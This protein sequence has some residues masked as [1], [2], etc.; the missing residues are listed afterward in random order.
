MDTAIF[1]V[2]LRFVSTLASA[3]LAAATANPASPFTRVARDRPLQHGEHVRHTSSQDSYGT[4]S[5]VCKAS[6]KASN[7]FILPLRFSPPPSHPI[8][9]LILRS[10]AIDLA[11]YDYCLDFSTI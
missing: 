8:L 4:E 6:I 3:T 5:K 2:T 1:I 9:S 11:Q 10:R 7:D